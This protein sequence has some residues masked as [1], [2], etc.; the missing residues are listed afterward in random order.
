MSSPRICYAIGYLKVIETDTHT[1]LMNTVVDNCLT[2]SRDSSRGVVLDARR[3][4]VALWEQRREE[5]DTR[6]LV[7]VPTPVSY[8]PDRDAPCGGDRFG[9]PVRDDSVGRAIGLCERSHSAPCRLRFSCALGRRP[10]PHLDIED[11]SPYDPQ[12]PT[13]SPLLK[14]PRCEDTSSCL[15]V[16][17]TLVQPDFSSPVGGQEVVDAT[18]VGD[19]SMSSPPTVDIVV[20]PVVPMEEHGGFDDVGREEQGQVADDY[21]TVGQ[22]HEYVGSQIALAL[23]T[24]DR[25]LGALDV[26]SSTTENRLDALENQLNEMSKFVL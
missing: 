8:E 12:N 3:S 21:Y 6:Q 10:R 18:L 20:E 16:V 26:W 1:A 15:P 7:M 24:V 14:V 19:V 23:A 25:Q 2:R 22:V 11:S 5:V 17:A 4:L 13:W 9:R